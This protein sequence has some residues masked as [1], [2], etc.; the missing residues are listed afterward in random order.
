MS[1]SESHRFIAQ[2]VL[3]ADDAKVA[4]EAER[5]QAENQQRINDLA[6]LHAE[7]RA[8]IEAHLANLA[9]GVPE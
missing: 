7:R 8:A 5:L 1:H 4:A 9:Q 3:E 6:R 2:L